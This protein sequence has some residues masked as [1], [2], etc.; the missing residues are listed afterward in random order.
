MQ[1]I[2]FLKCFI[3]TTTL[4]NKTKQILFNKAINWESFSKIIKLLL[5]DVSW[6]LSIIWNSIDIFLRVFEALSE[7]V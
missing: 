1:K 2:A 3:T 4:L 5:H 7:R 6:N